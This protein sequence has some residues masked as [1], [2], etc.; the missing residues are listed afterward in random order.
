M[1]QRELRDVFGCFATG[2]TIITTREAD[3]TPVGLTAN[4]F[5]SVSLDPPL[6]LFN[7]ERG[8]NCAS[9]FVEG[10]AFTVNILRHDQQAQSN[11]FASKIEDKFASDEFVW[12][13]GKNGCP[14]L[15][16]ALA[17]LECVCTSMHDGG[18][19]IIIIGRVTDTSRKKSGAP[20]LYF[21]GGYA[22][23][24]GEW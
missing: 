20:L 5:S 21:K 17:N 9:A 16:Q 12:S 13:D 4:S 18:D 23:L 6:I 1:D 11:H 14:R 8:A 10:G 2:I 19:H 24:E 22:G 7:L 3:G 15:V